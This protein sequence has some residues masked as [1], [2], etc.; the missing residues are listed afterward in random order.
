METFANQLAALTA[1][2]YKMAEAQAKVAHDAILFAMHKSGFK[3][4][5]T[6]KGGVVMCE[7][8][9]AVRRTTMD[10]DIDFVRYSISE[11]SVR[12]VVARWARMSGLKIVI[13]GTVK[14][15]RQE[16]YRGK[17]VYLDITDGSIKAPVR[18][19]VDI[20]V[21]THASIRQDERRFGALSGEK[22][23]TLFANT[24]EQIFA[25]KLLSLIKH[26]AL[27]TRAKDVFDLYY[28]TGEVNQ[29]TLR[30]VL[31][32][33]VLQNKKCPIREP[34]KILEAV[35]RTFK[36]KRFIRDMTVAKAN[37][38]KLPPTKVT[39]GV[40]AFLQRMLIG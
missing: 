36:S 39:A 28:L 4:N 21:H 15:L 27:S 17:R 22:A 10:I 40:L 13:F 6:V 11:A 35:G 1:D 19:K 3:K 30:K 8:T 24:R 7:L 29:R 9:K 2:G 38:L 23:A 14:D 34:V 18:T 12:R 26:G 31:R 33:L 25:E 16:D 20:G 37:W 32:D 5:C